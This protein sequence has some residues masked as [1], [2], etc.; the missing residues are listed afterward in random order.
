MSKCTRL[1]ALTLIV[2]ACVTTPAA[3]RRLKPITVRVPKFQVPPNTDREVCTFVRVPLDEGVDLAAFA[4]RSGDAR[5][6]R[7]A[8]AEAAGTSVETAIR[9]LRRFHREGIIRGAVGHVSVLDLPALRRI[10]G[11]LDL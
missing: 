8:L 9:V 2:L 11:D 3:A 6:T 5:I 10:A 7:R 1:V 4:V